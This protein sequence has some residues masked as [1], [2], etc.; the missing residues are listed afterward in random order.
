[1]TFE[2]A[3]QF[4]AASLRVRRPL[5]REKK[6]RAERK[7]GKAPRGR[8]TRDPERVTPASPICYRPLALVVSG[9]ARVRVR[10]GGGMARR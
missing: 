3:S 9:A 2:R 5:Q 4:F 1:M 7:G 8:M 6:D 10:V